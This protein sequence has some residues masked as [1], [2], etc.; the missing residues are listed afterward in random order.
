MPNDTSSIL[1]KSLKDAAARDRLF[2]FLLRQTGIGRER[3]EAAL[4][5]LPVVAFAESSPLK[6]QRSVLYFRSIR[7]LFGLVHTVTGRA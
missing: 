3:V 4:D 7:F 1:L 2:A 6:R 5:H